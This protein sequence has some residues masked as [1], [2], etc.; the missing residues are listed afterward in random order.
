MTEPLAEESPDP[1]AAPGRVLGPHPVVTTAER[2]MTIHKNAAHDLAQRI[3]SGQRITAR[4][5]VTGARAQTL[6]DWWSTIARNGREEGLDAVQVLVRYSRWIG[7]YLV[8]D[9]P[10]PPQS[11][12]ETASD[13]ARAEDELAL[14]HIEY[15]LALL[16]RSAA[17]EFLE[18]ASVFLPRATG[19]RRRSDDRGLLDGQEAE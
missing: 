17:R 1:V 6:R 2:A 10:T 11:G 15:G 19:A 5:L 4:H 14:M 9:R 3:S 7:T 13:P 18:T 8:I 16:M 12:D